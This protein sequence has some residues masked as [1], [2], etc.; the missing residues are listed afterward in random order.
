MGT[1]ISLSVLKQRVLTVAC[2]CVKQQ[3]AVSMRFL[4]QKWLENAMDIA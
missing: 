3:Y 4:S 1:G 2:S